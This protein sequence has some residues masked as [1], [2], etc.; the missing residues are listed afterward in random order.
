MATSRQVQNVLKRFTRQLKNANDAVE[1]LT[2]M[3][4]ELEEALEVFNAD[5]DVDITRGIRGE[6]KRGKKQITELRKNIDKLDR[7]LGDTNRKYQYLSR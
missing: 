2:K 1:D 5:E 3:I 6:I 7:E 4:G